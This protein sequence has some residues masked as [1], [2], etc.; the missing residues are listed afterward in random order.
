MTQATTIPRIGQEMPDGTIY[1][2]LSPETNQPMYTMPADAP[3]TMTFNQANGYAA[4]L[5]AHGHTDWRVPTKA[6]MN[7]LFNNRAAIGGF[8]IV[9]D[10]EAS[11]WYCSN[12]LVASFYPF[13]LP[14][15][16][17]NPVIQCAV[18]RFRDG[19]Q[20]YYDSETH[21]TSLRCVR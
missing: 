16:Y 13:T 19:S 17:Q 1:A 5:D 18:Q 4:Q 8:K 10:Y 9:P 3:L 15:G 12:S 14:F 6:E 20:D 11:A 2:G 7:V 21:T